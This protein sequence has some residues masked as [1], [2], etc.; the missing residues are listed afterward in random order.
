MRTT[1]LAATA[2][3]SAALL[4]L[5]ACGTS[6]SGS[7]S[8][9]SS[10]SGSAAKPAA[11]KAPYADLSGPQLLEKSLAAT[12]KATSMTVKGSVTEDKKPMTMELS[13]STGD[14]CRGSMA[15]AGEGRFELIKSK[16]NAYVKAD[17]AFYRAAGKGEPKEQTD[18]VVKM[19]ADRWMKS[20][21]DSPDAKDF[22]GICDLDELLKEFEDNSGTAHKGAV[23]TVD[24]QQ[25]VALTVPADG[26]TGTVYVAAKGEPFLLKAVQKD[27]D[28][29]GEM[30]FSDFNRPVDTTPPA[31]KDVVDISKL[32]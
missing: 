27:G 17:E 25:A 19:L 22:T 16:K 10:A 26:G 21:A 23:T 32:G 6:G 7:D 4:G 31:D 1:T 15:T 13:L 20:P 12:R 28:D 5:T 8:G 24:G 30:T 14:E 3:A 29:P 2:L 18:A 11:Q 9:S